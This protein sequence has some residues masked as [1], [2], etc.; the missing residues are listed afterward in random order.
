M[1]SDGLAIAGSLVVFSVVDVVVSV[2][3]IPVG[4]T[5]LVF[6]DEVLLRFPY[7]VVA[8]GVLRRGERSYVFRNVHLVLSHEVV[9]PRVHLVLEESVGNTQIIVR[10]N[11]DG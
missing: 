7:V 6:L 9:D 11:S 2:L 3:G 8:V 5:H 10:M 1:L 4:V